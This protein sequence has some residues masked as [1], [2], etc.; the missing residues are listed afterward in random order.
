LQIFFAKIKARNYR[1]IVLKKAESSLKKGRSMAKPLTKKTSS[2]AA[3]KPSVLAA[4]E[5]LDADQAKLT[6]SRAKLLAD[7][8]N[9]LLAQ[10]QHIVSELGSL[11]FSYKLS[12]TTPGPSKSP[13]KSMEKTVQHKP[14]G[15]CPVCLFSTRPAHD[16][17]THRHMPEKKAFTAAELE[18]RG[19]VRL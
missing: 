17:R 1:Q 14:K 9:D 5:K 6:E 19:L 13:K 18:E 15:P 16:A 7:A 4:L 12:P 8:K 3:P 10:G 11:G 2:T